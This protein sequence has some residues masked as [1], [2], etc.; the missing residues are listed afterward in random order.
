[1]RQFYT[2]ELLLPKKCFGKSC[3]L[4]RPHVEPHRLLSTATG[5]ASGMDVPVKGLPAQCSPSNHL[6]SGSGLQGRPSAG[7]AAKASVALRPC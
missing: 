3:K 4:A 6:G 2:S 5:G 7:L 1:M